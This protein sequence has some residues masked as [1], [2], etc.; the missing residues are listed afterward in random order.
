MSSSCVPVSVQCKKKVETGFTYFISPQQGEGMEYN[1]RGR[2]R[3]HG[4]GCDVGV[5]MGMVRVVVVVVGMGV[6][7]GM[8]AWG[9]ESGGE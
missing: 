4:H 8:S 5:G 1:K 3:G 6:G 9:K 7:V 2:G